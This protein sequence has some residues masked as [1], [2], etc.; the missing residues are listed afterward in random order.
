MKFTFSNSF[1]KHKTFGSIN[2]RK[3]FHRLF[4]RE[5]ER[6]LRN[7]GFFSLMVMGHPNGGTAHATVEL[8]DTL[9]S[10]IR[11]IDDLGWFDDEQIGVILPETTCEGA[12]KLGRDIQRRM[13]A[14]NQAMV[15][16]IHT[17]PEENNHYGQP[18][19]RNS[20]KVVPGGMQEF[21]TLFGKPIPLWKRVL[22]ITGALIAAVMLLPLLLAIAIY[23]KAVSPGP[24]F[25]R[26]ERLGY[27]RKPFI[28]W[29]FRTMKVNAD[30]C[31]HRNH[32][33]DLIRNGKTMVKID[34]QP[35]ACIIPF[36]NVLRKLGLDELPQLINVVR[37][38]MSLIGPRPCM[39]YEAVEF[40]D[41]Q[42]RRFDTHP[43]LTGLWQVSGKNRTTF[44]EMMRLDIKYGQ[45]RSLYRDILIFFKTF[46]A[47]IDQA[48]ENIKFKLVR[49]ENL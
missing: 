13:A 41:W 40:L 3:A 48:V 11:H 27:L 12:Q 46:P 15:F 42:N 2:S 17:Y 14:I 7:Y 21:F 29:K 35:D 34:N 8:I 22:D 4:D 39:D 10:R 9:K 26:Q 45:K 49:R 47:I 30:Q 37:G 32:V 6:A 25:F 24:V 28:C 19:N 5:R 31:K 44:E 1:L 43:G 23:I 20:L 18:V 33:A 16:S 38:D 36:G